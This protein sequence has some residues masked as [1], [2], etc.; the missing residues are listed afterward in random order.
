[1]ILIIDRIKIMMEHDFIRRLVM[2]LVL[3][4]AMSERLLAYVIQ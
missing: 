1:M 2:W 3:G 4:W